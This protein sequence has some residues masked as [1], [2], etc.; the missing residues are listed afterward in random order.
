M[1]MFPVQPTPTNT[2]ITEEEEEVSVE[3]DLDFAQEETSN[4]ILT[5]KTNQD[6]KFFILFLFRKC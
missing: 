6:N 4:A 3:E 1:T 5:I 2:T